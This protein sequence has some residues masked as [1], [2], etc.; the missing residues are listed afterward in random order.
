[1]IFQTTSS[2]VTPF[3]VSSSGNLGIGTS[4]S[5]R[6]TI[7]SNGH[8]TIGMG[9]PYPNSVLHVFSEKFET[10][11]DKLFESIILI[12]K[13]VPDIDGSLIKKF[14]D[15]NER[16]GSDDS[17]IIKSFEDVENLLTSI[18][19]P[20]GIKRSIFEV[21]QEIA[22]YKIESRMVEENPI[23]DNIFERLDG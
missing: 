13:E 18:G 1:M 6:L 23:T 15:L 5:T 4:G 21:S 10:L 20:M 14:L 9:T 16:M 22:S 3:Y 2:S 12:S 19:C 17:S 7:S 8:A 11:R